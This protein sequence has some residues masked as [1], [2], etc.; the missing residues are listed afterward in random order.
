MSSRVL[1][2]QVDLETILFYS[3]CDGYSS[4][5]SCGVTLPTGERPHCMPICVTRNTHV[6]RQKEVPVTSR[7][8][9]YLS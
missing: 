2:E 9:P 8:S 1:K 6:T 3:N 7:I 5:H 4:F